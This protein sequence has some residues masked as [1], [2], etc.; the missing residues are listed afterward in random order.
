MRMC[1]GVGM[2]VCVCVHVHR[3]AHMSMC[4]CVCVCVCERR[5]GGHAVNDADT[6]LQYFTLKADHYTSPW[7][8]LSAWPGHIHTKHTALA[9]MG[10]PSAVA[11]GHPKP[12]E[13]SSGRQRAMVSPS[14]P[15]R[16]PKSCLVQPRHPSGLAALLALSP[17]SRHC[18]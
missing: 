14:V 10:K 1:K 8:S 13:S 4:M 7:H 11:A 2:C 18:H 17:L 5:E 3:C 9:A 16:P 12:G 6:Q 15:R